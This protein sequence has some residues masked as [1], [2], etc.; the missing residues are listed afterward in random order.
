MML[1]R[2]L[3]NRGR[4]AHFRQGL[5]LKPRLCTL[6]WSI[7]D[8]RFD[9]KKNGVMAEP[10]PA[11]FETF[12]D[13]CTRNIKGKKQLGKPYVKNPIEMGT[14]FAMGCSEP[15]FRHRCPTLA[16]RIFNEQAVLDGR[17]VED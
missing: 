3:A 16:H 10:L 4:L 6:Q 8:G 2:L 12:V 11:F 15:H 7:V 1:T 5:H 9:C 14:C 17:M 13:R